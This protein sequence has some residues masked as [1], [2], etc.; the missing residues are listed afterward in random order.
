MRIAVCIKQVPVVS[1]MQFDPDTKTLK[2]E[3]VPSEVSAFDVRALVKAVELKAAHGG[4]VVAVTM[5]PPQAREALSECLALGADRAVHICDRAFAGSDTLATARALALALRRESFDLVLCG[6]NS[7]DAETGQVGPEVAEL[8]DWP[9][10]T[11]ARTLTID[12]TARQLSAER[13]TDDGVETVSAP[14][15]A[16]VTAAEDLA[17]ER[18]PSKA[19][20]EAAKTKPCVDLRAAELSS[21]ISQFG[22]AGSPT[23][24]AGLHH[25][26]STRLGRILEASSIDTA[27][28]ELSRI[29]TQEHGLFD[30]WK[31]RAQPAIATVA[32]TAQRSRARDVWVL[33]EVLGSALRP[34]VFELLAKATALA[35]ATGGHVGAVLLGRDVEPHAAALAAHGADRVLLADDARLAPYCTEVHAAVFAA[36]IQAHAPGIVLI[37]ST[38]MGRDLAP[39]VAARLQLGLTG[40]CV[41]IGI[42]AAGRLLQYKPAFGGS[43]VAPIL[44][45]TL[46]EMA[47]VRP[48]MLSPGQ[49]DP[50]RQVVIERVALDAVGPPRVRVVER[51]AGAEAAAELDAAEVVIGV[52]KG[53]GS[54]DNLQRVEPL[55]RLLN[56]ALCTTRDVTDD[57]WLPKQYQVGLTG[58]AI[59]PKL[60]IAIGIRG[61]FEHMVGVRRAGLIVA[62]N[63]NAK[64]P[65]FKNADY[66]MVGDY[67]E[68]VSALHTHLSTIQR[69][70]R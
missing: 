28:A 51:H 15:P 21:D 19:D 22:S 33:A 44:S 59:A 40:D 39:R 41:D 4:E 65:V 2:R 63:K 55:R 26:E 36:A 64:A 45:R 25:I 60:Y 17:P 69:R 38:S 34:V 67:V 32:A 12:A 57:G 3:G 5:G 9:Q 8:L 50:S 42:D 46:P 62:I 11:A 20:R 70:Q 56:A 58:R 16:L 49:P 61:A 66:G 68:A 24:V 47:T 1:A 30:T 13:E 6:R 31:V 54:K 27:A 7:V 43:V 23:W 48:G 52:G 18:F 35:A 53:I 29:L 10:I 37:P 14:L